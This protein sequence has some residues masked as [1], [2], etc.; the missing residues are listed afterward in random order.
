MENKHFGYSTEIKQARG[1]RYCQTLHLKNDPTSIELYK[2]WHR[3]E[4]LWPE[5]PQGIRQVGIL[6]MEIYIHHNILIMI[7]EVDTDFDWDNAFGKLA[8]LAK[9]A[10]WESFVAQFQ[11]ADPSAT[12]MHKWQLMERIFKL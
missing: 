10:E 9:Q 8:T 6:D 5:I 3:P 12:S 1:K 11:L 4:N 7:V 2:Y